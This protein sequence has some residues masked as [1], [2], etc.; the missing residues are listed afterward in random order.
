MHEEFLGRR[1]DM[2]LRSAFSPAQQDITGVERYA[3]PLGL[4]LEDPLRRLPQ[5]RYLELGGLENH[6]GI[7]VSNANPRVSTFRHSPDRVQ[8]ICAVHLA[9]YVFVFESCLS[10]SRSSSTWCRS[11]SG[12]SADREARHRARWRPLTAEEE[13]VAIAELRALA[14][15]RGDLLAEVAGIF[16][17]TSE[18]E[19][20]E[21]FA[22]CAA[23]LCRLAGA[24]ESLIPQ[25]VEEGRRRAAVVRVPAA[26]RRAPVTALFAKPDHLLAGLLHSHAGAVVPRYI[27]R[28]SPNTITAVLVGVA[29]LTLLVK[30]SGRLV[31]AEPRHR[32]AGRQRPAG[33]GH[34]GRPVRRDAAAR[35]PRR[36][37][38]PGRVTP[39]LHAVGQ[40]GQRHGADRPG[41]P[42]G[43]PVRPGRRAHR[44]VRPRT[45]CWCS[46]RSGCRA[47]P[48]PPSR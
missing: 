17:G 26:W 8:F 32:A 21:P 43:Q 2:Q 20:D 13:A 19:L 23:Y 10:G 3:E 25:W 6:P 47:T 44:T 40:C 41:E 39:V 46:A 12:G 14:G 24:D 5:R 38:A 36:R 27:E 7:H 28:F 11:D 29:G 48:R 4:S 1:H 37:A 45:A 42:A 18:G 34:P 31:L 30:A 16:E 15:G 9:V 33:P 35:R 22:R